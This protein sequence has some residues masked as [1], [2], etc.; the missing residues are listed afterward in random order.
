MGKGLRKSLRVYVSKLTRPVGGNRREVTDRRRGDALDGG[1]Q[2]CGATLR[3]VDRF[4]FENFRSIYTTTGGGGG[5]G[6]EDDLCNLAAG[7]SPPPPPRF[8]VE[9]A[10]PS[11]G[12]G[13]GGVAVVTFSRDPCEDFRRS[14]QEMMGARAPFD[15]ELAE[16]LFFCFLE[17][18]D[19]SLHRHILRAFGTLVLAVGRLTAAEPGGAPAGGVKV[20]EGN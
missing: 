14:M 15:W 3:D 4:L 6:G 10:P 11:R 5:D 7:E 20:P 17:L 1:N 18:N 9:R 19:R 2:N 8:F 12:G 16:E 13:G